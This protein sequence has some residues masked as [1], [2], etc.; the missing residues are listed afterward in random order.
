MKQF[1]A[2]FAVACISGKGLLAQYPVFAPSQS[3]NLIYINPGFS[4]NDRCPHIGTSYLLQSWKKKALYQTFSGEFD[5]RVPSLNGAIGI[6]FK[7]DK[8]NNR[9]GTDAAGLIYAYELFISRSFTLKPSVN[10]DFTK[11]KIDLYDL[12]GRYELPTHK[13]PMP[14]NTFSSSKSSLSAGA[15]ILAYTRDLFGGIFFRNL[16]RPVESKIGSTEFRNPAQFSSIAGF[17]LYGLGGDIYPIFVYESQNGKYFI[18]SL[19]I[20][21]IEP[22]DYWS[23]NL[24]YSSGALLAGL[25][26]RSFMGRAASYHVQAG[27]ALRKVNLCYNI[28]LSPFHL[29][30]GTKTEMFYHQVTLEYR[31]RCRAARAK[32]RTVSCPSFGS[33][34]SGKGHVYRMSGYSSGINPRFLSG[35]ASSSYNAQASQTYK[36]IDA[37][38]G[39]LTAGEIN[40]FSKWNLWN[41]VSKKELSEFQK[42]WKMKPRLRYAVHVINADKKPV[43]NC[44]AKLMDGNG[45]VIWA[46]KTDNMGKAEL[47]TELFEKNKAPVYLEVKHGEQTAK[48]DSIKSFDKGVNTVTLPVQCTDPSKADILFMVDATGSMGDEI[49]YLKTELQDIIS[50]CKKDHPETS[51]LLGSLFYRCKGNSYVTKKS[52]FSEDIRQTIDFI[53]DQKA[54]EGGDESVEVALTEAVNDFKWRENASTRIIFIV[55]DETPGTS[56]SILRTLHS[57]VRAAAE[58]GIRVIPLVASGTGYASKSLEYLMR[59]IALATNGTYVFLT[60]HS[61]VGNKHTAPS[62]D[63]YDVEYMNK[64]LLRLITQ[65]MSS[66]CNEIPIDYVSEMKD[67]TLVEVIEHV[68]LDST[69]YFRHLDLLANSDSSKKEKKLA[70]QEGF[71]VT[72]DTLYKKSFRFYPNPSKGKVFIEC[73]G[74]IKALYLCDMN[75]K[76]ITRFPVMQNDI[77]EIDISDQLD[78]LYNLIYENGKKVF[79]G[80]LVLM[81]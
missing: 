51:L 12:G 76:L 13:F 27:C 40:D 70:K 33:G 11:T 79:S 69:R 65:C 55:L 60:D 18:D 42:V 32:F 50:Q 10:L 34:G 29:A 58:K 48:L 53:K 36:D 3:S 37:K 49:N 52:P 21:L 45:N 19:G 41:D 78:G 75:G 43:I 62:A 15:G 1:Y 73:Q 26:Y 64:L 35:N 7:Q 4:G 57:A 46:G 54:D 44:S 30:D 66:H 74:D 6:R 71:K 9:T 80:K 31:F 28:G 61:G 16:N 8:L 5:M 17:K 68:I 20:D 47:W 38:P 2:L 59:S 56:D 39:T 67:T 77:T 63:A 25:G 14:P 72:G 23:V 81:K 24:N 22:S